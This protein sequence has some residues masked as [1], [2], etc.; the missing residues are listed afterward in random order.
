[1]K[2]TVTWMSSAEQELA[3]LWLAS[4]DRSTVTKAAHVLD[5]LLRD[6][7]EKEGESRPYDSRILF[8]PPLGIIYPVRAEEHH[9]AVFHVWRFRTSHS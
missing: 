5:Q 2:Y 6:D 3:A 1:M 7:P 9:V 8:S 4:P